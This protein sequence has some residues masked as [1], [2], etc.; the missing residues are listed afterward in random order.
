MQQ[1]TRPNTMI[2]PL[3]PTRPTRFMNF[4][5]ASAIVVVAAAGSIIALTTWRTGAVHVG[6]SILPQARYFLPYLLAIALFSTGFRVLGDI[7]AV[8][9]GSFAGFYAAAIT[10]V[11]G[12]PEAALVC[13]LQIIMALSALT[14]LW[15]SRKLDF[16]P[17]PLVDRVLGLGL[18]LGIFLLSYGLASADFR[19]KEKRQ[20]SEDWSKR[21]EAQSSALAWSRDSRIFDLLRLAQCIEKFRGDSVGGP[22][23]AS[24][25]QLYRWSVDS[26]SHSA[27]C[28]S[29]LFMRK[30]WIIGVDSANQPALDT[31]P[32]PEIEDRH[33]LVY[34]EPPSRRRVDRFQRARFTLGI[35]AVW[36]SVE[37][38]NAVHQ[39]GTRNFLLDTAGNIHVTTEHRRA[40][41]ADPLA[42]PC[43][44]R[45]SPGHEDCAPPY[46][47]RERWGLIT[48]LPRLTLLGNDEV[49]RTDSASVTIWFQPVNA[50]DSIASIVIEWSDGRRPT[51]IQPPVSESIGKGP[52]PL[53]QFRVSH[54]YSD[55]GQKKVHVTLT[56]RSGARYEADRPIFIDE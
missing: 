33:H 8:L 15:A 3:A 51:R 41:T 48:E 32:R 45:E 40:T 34:Y 36:D 9:L 37:F 14:D 16:Q 20:I 39:P 42:R 47:S 21:V 53:M 24:L 10:L 56:T 28:A 2:E 54:L 43:D 6:S 44:S 50:L 35:E 25:R 26:A 49:A 5:V 17:V 4:T 55:W 18:P 31:L 7:G 30:H 22:A 46:Q 13:A 27:H 23:P 29:H 38:P 11:S 1:R 52:K 12:S 19:A